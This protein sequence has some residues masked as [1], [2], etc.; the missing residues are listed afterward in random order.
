MTMPPSVAEAEDP[1]VRETRPPQ[2]LL[3]DAGVGSVAHRLH[4]SAKLRTIAGPWM[5]DHDVEWRKAQRCAKRNKC[6]R[7]L[8]AVK[9]A[10]D[11]QVNSTIKSLAVLGGGGGLKKLALIAPPR[12]EGI[13]YAARDGH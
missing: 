7:R 2:R 5:D 4:P 9:T 13:S 10:D 12:H 6:H 11:G 3:I 8:E 1:I